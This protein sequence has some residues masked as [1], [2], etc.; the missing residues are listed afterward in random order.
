[1]STESYPSPSEAEHPELPIY[2]IIVRGLYLDSAG[3]APP[4]EQ[5]R[6]HRDKLY[7]AVASVVRAAGYKP[8]VLADSSSGY[9]VPVRPG[10]YPDTADYRIVVGSDDMSRAEA[11]E[12]GDRMAEAAGLTALTELPESDRFIPIG[13]LEAAPDETST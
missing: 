6:E 13:M 7:D 5:V 8:P 1:M 2:G 9:H 12:L 10:L 11:A 3:V 4:I